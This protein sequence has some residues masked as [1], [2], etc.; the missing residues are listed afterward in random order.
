MPCFVGSRLATKNMN[1]NVCIKI[2][3]KKKEKKRLFTNV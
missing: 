3:T 1:N 2:Y